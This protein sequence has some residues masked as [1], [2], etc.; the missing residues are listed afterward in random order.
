MM[1]AFAALRYD[2]A[3]HPR[4]SRQQPMPGGP[5]D[6]EHGG[7]SGFQ[8]TIFGVS[9]RTTPTAPPEQPTV[10]VPPPAPTWWQRPDPLAKDPAKGTPEDAA[11][12]TPSSPYAAVPEDAPHWGDPAWTPVD[13]ATH[14]WHVK[15]HAKLDALLQMETRSWRNGDVSAQNQTASV[16]SPYRGSGGGFRSRSGGG[17]GFGGGRGRGVAPS[18]RPGSSRSGPARRGRFHEFERVRRYDGDP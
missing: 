5:V 9:F 3:K 6:G 15:D 14:E 17:G 8:G 4:R 1:L 16:A 13:P 2:P 11:T 12:D 18:S 7:T 10:P